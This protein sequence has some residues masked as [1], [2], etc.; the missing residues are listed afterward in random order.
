MPIFCPHIIKRLSQAEFGPSAYR[1]MAE[2][3]AMH[4]ELGRLFDERIYQRELARRLGDAAVHVP[5]HVS[6]RTFSKTYNL[7]VVAEGSVVIELKATDAIHDRHR[8]Q[9]MNYLFLLDIPHGKIVNLRTETVEHEFVNTTMTTADRKT[10]TMDRVCW[11]PSAMGAEY[12]LTVLMELAKEWGLGL[13]LMLYEEALSHFL[14]GERN[15]VV[16]ADDGLALGRQRLRMAEEGTAFRLTAFRHP[17]DTYAEHCSRQLKYLPLQAI[18][19]ANLT[20]GR[21]SLRTIRSG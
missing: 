15:L 20:M 7:D 5:I 2:V 18:L 16:S 21:I 19:W 10:F 17:P 6:Y 12:F 1:V 11:D 9:L 3:F 13:E 8:A 4:R 14:A